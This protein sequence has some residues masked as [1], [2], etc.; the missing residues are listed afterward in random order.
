MTPAPQANPWWGWV[1]YRS[2]TSMCSV[3][4]HGAF[5]HVSCG[6]GCHTESNPI[7]KEFRAREDFDNVYVVRQWLGFLGA[8]DGTICEASKTQQGEAFTVFWLR[9]NYLE[10]KADG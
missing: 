10:G 3:L 5:S 2:H 8:W 1:N 7:I 4:E 9:L 6:C